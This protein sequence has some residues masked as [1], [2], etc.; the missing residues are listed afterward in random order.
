[1]TRVG[2]SPQVDHRDEV[3]S[4]SSRVQYVGVDT[5]HNVHALNPWFGSPV[6]SNRLH[7][8]LLNF[9]R[10]FHRRAK[11]ATAL[12][13]QAIVLRNAFGSIMCASFASAC[14]S[15]GD[16]F[17][18]KPSRDQSRSE[19]IVAN[20]F[21]ATITFCIAMLI[22]RLPPMLSLR[23][24]DAPDSKPTAWLCLKKLI[25]GTFVYFL[26]T[27]VGML[28]CSS[29]VAYLA[30]I[31]PSLFKYKLDCY[32]GTLST[33]GFFTGITIVS[34]RIYYRETCQG[35]ERLMLAQ[36]TPRTSTKRTS[37]TASKARP[38]AKLSFRAA[39]GAR[40]INFWRAYIK[41]FPK[42]T[43]AALAG[44]FVHVLS[45]QRIM[46]QGATA[47][48]CFVITSTFFKLFIQESTKHYIL[49]KRIRSIKFMCAAVALPTVLI[50]TQ[51]RI[52]LLGT[53][54]AQLVAMGTIGMAFVEIFLR[55]VKA[56]L[57]MRTIR[58]R[59]ANFP[60]S[61]KSTLTT[62]PQQPVSNITSSSPSPAKVDF[63]LWRRRLHAYHIA[64]I[65][66]DT[67]AEYIAIGCSASILFFFGDHPCY[68]LLR[69]PDSVEPR[70]QN[71]IQLKM[72]L[73]QVGV[74]VI[75]DFVSTLL[76][77]MAGI[78]FDL[79]KNIES[80]LTVLFIV[81]AV[82]NINISVGIY[83]L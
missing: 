70:N 68:S 69:Q 66:A 77:M 25:R 21:W 28:A 26:V 53:K 9:F 61:R 34:R 14:Y 23:F 60:E 56:N 2:V 73:L 5:T 47:L 67:Y 48:T 8:G 41:E 18:G 64:E 30:F 54:N 75:V 44:A 40:S 38:E 3:L 22:A 52:I 1:M 15:L 72:L 74:E 51:T 65:N 32:V 80:F 39:Y 16:V 57:I 11:W 45:Q 63:E 82:L 76:E 49:K 31:K 24:I 6:A 46:D 79:I 71:S 19:L 62:L 29:F 12:R 37:R 13:T 81:T 55:V 27:L 33:H 4:E 36:Q 35:R 83:L 50:D 20:S 43:P 59:R 78:E 58:N 7:L 42:S 10:D 17:S